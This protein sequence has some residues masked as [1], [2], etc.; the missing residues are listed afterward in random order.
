MIEVFFYLKEREM[1]LFFRKCSP[2]PIFTQRAQTRLSDFL[3]FM[4]SGF[5]SFNLASYDLF[6]IFQ[7]KPRRT[8]FTIIDEN[9][10]EP[11]LLRGVN[12]ICI[13]LKNHAVLWQMF[14]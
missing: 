9:Y 6:R 5:A 12:Q 2:M 4:S 7:R 8:A 13:H 11:V 14:T 1:S 3:D 10:V